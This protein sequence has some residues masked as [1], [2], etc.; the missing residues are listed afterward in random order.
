MDCSPPGSSDHGD[1]PGKNT[2]V[3]CHA[4]LQGIFPTQR[5]NPGLPHCRQILYHLSHQGSLLVK[6]KSLFSS[7]KGNCEKKDWCPPVSWLW[8]ELQHPSSSVLY[9]FSL[10]L[11]SPQIPIFTGV[12]PQKCP[13]C[14]S[15]SMTP[16]FSSFHWLKPSRFS[17]FFLLRELVLF[18]SIFFFLES[19]VF[20]IFN[21]RIIALQCCVGFC[22]TKSWISQKYTYISS[23]LSLPSH[24]LYDPSRSS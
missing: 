16:L 7:G 18:F 10:P 8:S 23:L 5:L 14:K 22:H 19:F 2:G 21:W 9:P 17:F 6:K 11:I 13:G 15:I 4:L 3:G 1:S 20:L 24:P 12:W